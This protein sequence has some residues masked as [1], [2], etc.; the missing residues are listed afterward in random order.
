MTDKRRLHQIVHV[1][2]TLALLKSAGRDVSRFKFK[3][4]KA[5]LVKGQRIMPGISPERYTAMLLSYYRGSTTD[6]DVLWHI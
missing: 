4:L 5:L 6:E 3:G 2:E 1:K